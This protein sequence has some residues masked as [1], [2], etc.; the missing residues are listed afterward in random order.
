[1]TQEE[2]KELLRR[3]RLGQCS[4]RELEIIDKWYDALGEENEFTLFNEE[5]D[6][7][8]IKKDID[9]EVNKK[10]SLEEGEE[11]NLKIIRLSYYLKVAAVFLVALSVIFVFYNND[12]TTNTFSSEIAIKSLDQKLPK[13]QEIR[14]ADGS[15]VWVK[16][17]SRLEYPEEFTGNTREVHLFG[18]AFFEVKRDVKRPFIIYSGNIKTKVLGTSFN[19]KAFERENLAEVA[20]VTGKVSVTVKEQ[21]S[22]KMEEVILL[23]NQKATF[24]KEFN[25][26]VRV[27]EKNA[28]KFKMVA[29][30]EM[31]FDEA[32][33]KDISNTISLA[34]GIDIFLENEGIENCIITADLTDQ[35]LESTLKILTR[36]IG[37]RYTVKGSKIE[38]SGKGCESN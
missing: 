27:E 14:L 36:S 1:M 22:S 3:F 18:E 31:I 5:L 38:I 9:R 32:T 25:Q 29:K 33:M 7:N 17:G 12:K 8:Q 21:G 19:I 15:K 37:A 30:N 6:F 11:K 24:L 4:N 35:S 10:I 13:S 16:Q 23:R 26:L 34:Y 20:V 28:E 2:V